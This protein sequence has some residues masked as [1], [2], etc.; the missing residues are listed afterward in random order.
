MIHLPG[1]HL[2]PGPTPIAAAHTIKRMRAI[3]AELAAAG[4]Q[5]RLYQSP[6]SVDVTATWQGRHRGMEAV[7][8]E[9]NYVELRY[10]HPADATPAQIVAVITRVMD[11]ITAAQDP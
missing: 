10:W 6:G 4:L 8:D 7:V 5:T 2:M 3:A 1:G 9:D 11:T